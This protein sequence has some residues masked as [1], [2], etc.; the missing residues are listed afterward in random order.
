MERLPQSLLDPKLQLFRVEAA[1]KAWNR[2]PQMFMERFVPM[3]FNADGNIG[4][5]EKVN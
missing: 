1:Q 2:D 5:K 3:F 4:K